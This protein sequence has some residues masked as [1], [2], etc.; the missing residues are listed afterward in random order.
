MFVIF[1]FMVSM[2]SA[3]AA[4]RGGANEVVSGSEKKCCKNGEAN[5]CPY[6]VEPTQSGGVWGCQSKLVDVLQSSHDCPSAENG[7]LEMWIDTA[8]AANEITSILKTSITCESVTANGQLEGNTLRLSGAANTQALTVDGTLTANTRIKAEGGLE[9][10]G[11]LDATEKISIEAQGRIKIVGR[12]DRS[13]GI[14]FIKPNGEN[15]YFLGALEFN[16]DTIGFWSQYASGGAKWVVTIDKEGVITAPRFKGVAD[17]ATYSNSA[18]YSSSAGY[19]DYMRPRTMHW[20]S[21]PTSG[22]IAPTDIVQGRMQYAFTNWAF[23][24]ENEGFADSLLLNGWADIS[25]GNVN[26]LK[27]RKNQIGIR[28]EQGV[29]T[30]SSRMATWKD[31]TMTAG[32]DKRLKKNIQTIEDPLTKITQLRGVNFEWR[33]KYVT[34]LSNETS[35]M[36]FNDAY[37]EGLQMGFIAQEVD[38]VIPEVIERGHVGFEGLDNVLALDYSKITALLVEGI[39]ELNQKVEELSKKVE[40]LSKN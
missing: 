7:D 40:E 30:S 35:E 29:S 20:T 11:F 25:G 6:P 3:Q 23:N 32:S 19:S 13:P 9:V 24:T 31:V 17:S 34:S 16:V 38:K 33:E 37:D 26:I 1:I 5:C 28:V 39:K 2:Y 14:W 8:I 21:A 18:G 12:D 10:N 27:I 22:G 4:C 36:V 15:P